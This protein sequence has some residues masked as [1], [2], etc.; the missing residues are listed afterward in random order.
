[1]IASEALVD[2]FIER[3]TAAG[4]EVV[5][6]STDA[7]LALQVLE[8][9]SS[10]GIR[11]VTVWDDPLLQ[12]IV[13]AVRGAGL[14]I[15]HD[16]AAAAVGITAAEH[17]IAETGTLVLSAGPGRPRAT[18]LLPPLHVA[19]LPEDRIVGTLF[20]L[21]PRLEALPSALAFV[22]GPSRTADIELTPVRGAHGP[23]SVAVYLLP[24]ALGRA[25]V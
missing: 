10:A 16:P 19:V 18:S 25:P 23:V 7:S 11:A 2:R 4:V 5:R 1:M 14:T 20:D 17:A 21:M 15:T 9:I 8:R 6:V 13:D 22:T 24:D 3:A 12:P